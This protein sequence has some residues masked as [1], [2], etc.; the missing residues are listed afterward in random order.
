[1]SFFLFFLKDPKREL[2][3]LA[4][5]LEIKCDEQLAAEILNMTSFDSMKKHKE[6]EREKNDNPGGNKNFYRKGKKNLTLFNLFKTYNIVL[7]FKTYNIVSLFKDYNIVS[8]F[9]TYTIASISKTYNISIFK[10]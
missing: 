3:R 6:Q 10:T 9:K 7:L 5:F 2:F 4:E 8:L 1:M